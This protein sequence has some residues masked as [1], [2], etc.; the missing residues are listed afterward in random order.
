MPAYYPAN[1]HG[2]AE[3]PAPLDP[4]ITGTGKPYDF[5]LRAWMGASTISSYSVTVGAGLTK[6]SDARGTFTPSTTYLETGTFS[7]TASGA[8]H[9][10][11]YLI[12]SA[13]AQRGERYAVTVSVTDS[14]GL[15]HVMTGYVRVADR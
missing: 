9:V 4:D 12:A 6:V 7:D 15:P 1:G 11:V 13:S 10:R 8:D 3:F 14:Q 5:D 2:G